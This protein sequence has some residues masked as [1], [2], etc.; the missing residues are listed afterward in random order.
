MYAHLLRALL[1]TRE[2][3]VEVLLGRVVA[4]GGEDSVGAEADHG[5]DLVLGERLALLGERPTRRVSE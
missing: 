2:Q 5:E 3:R 4:G 1:A